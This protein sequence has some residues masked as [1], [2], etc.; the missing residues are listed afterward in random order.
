VPL[1]LRQAA[2]AVGATPWQVTR[3]HVLPAAI[4]GILTGTILSISRAIGETA[5]LLVVGAAL[6]L[7]RKPS[8]IM[9]SY[10]AIPIQI[11]AWTARPQSGFRDAAAAGIIVLLILLLTLN[12]A[13]II[14]RQHFSNK[15]RW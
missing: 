5:P 9:D 4:P 14:L 12:A 8:G 2:Y 3:H 15:T 1:S 11:Y 10:S 13:A 6:Y 7:T